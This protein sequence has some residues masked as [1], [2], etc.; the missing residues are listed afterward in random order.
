VRSPLPDVTGLHHALTYA[1]RPCACVCTCLDTHSPLSTS[2]LPDNDAPNDARHALTLVCRSTLDVL[3][4]RPINRRS[5]QLDTNVRASARHECEFTTPIDAS[6]VSATPVIFNVDVFFAEY[7]YADFRSLSCLGITLSSYGFFPLHGD[8]MVFA[9]LSVSTPK[10]CSDVNT[11]LRTRPN[12]PNPRV[13][14]IFRPVAL[15]GCM[16]LRDLFFSLALHL[17][18]LLLHPRARP[19]SGAQINAAL[20]TRLTRRSV[21]R[22]RPDTK[23]VRHRA[24]T[25]AV[26]PSFPTKRQPTAIFL[27]PPPA[28]PLRPAAVPAGCMPGCA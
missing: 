3:I 16:S 4:S 9:H 6:C 10:S 1:S 20:C 7:M 8:V 23:Y 2:S 12:E 11:L 21:R 13:S 22:I 19:Y 26:P 5:T 28:P 14:S 27:F 24:S 18:L 17:P 15:Q 25:C